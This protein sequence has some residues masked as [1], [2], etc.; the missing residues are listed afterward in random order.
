M[1]AHVDA[2][3]PLRWMTKPNWTE[4]VYTPDS[5]AVSMAIDLTTDA[6]SALLNQPNTKDLTLPIMP[7]TGL[8][9]KLKSSPGFVLIRCDSSLSDDTLRCVYAYY[10]RSL[11]TLN[12]RYGFFF[13]VVDQGLDYREAAIPVSKTKASTG[14]HTDSTAREYLPD[15]VGLLCLHPAVS[16]GDSLLTNAADLYIHLS[17]THPAAL[18]AMEEPIIR[19]VITPGTVNQ[20]SAIIENAFP[21]FAF[22]DQRFTFRYMRYWIETAFAKTERELPKTL[23]EGL[24]ATDAFFAD[25]SNAIQFRMERGDLLF[26]NNRFLCHNRTGFENHPHIEK[27]RTLVR[28]WINFNQT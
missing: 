28:T 17:E 27:A 19:D 8:L 26:I 16:G 24:D 13:D 4:H 1:H 12:N 2:V 11:G 25:Q 21:I 23:A 10:S 6:K 20:V 5:A 15:V 9:S 3:A 22:P 14:Y 18:S 7:V